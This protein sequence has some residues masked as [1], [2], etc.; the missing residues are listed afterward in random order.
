MQVAD[1]ALQTI[2]PAHLIG[3]QEIGAG[4]H[5]AVHVM[6][7]VS[8]ADQLQLAA[9]LELLQ[10]VLTD[11]LEHPKARLAAGVRAASD[12]TLGN[13]RLQASQDVNVRL[14]QAAHRLSGLQRPPA[15]E[16]GEATKQ[17]A[18]GIVQEILAPGDR[19]AQ[20]LLTGREITGPAGQE[21][22]PSFQPPSYRLRRQQPDA[23]SR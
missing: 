5:G 1:L 4:L 16:N 3:T 20:G 14:V 7:R 2:E 19:V 11:R 23:S 21:R 15:Q 9:R 13:E 18:L 12:K 17:P 10:P 6:H 22:Q 8:A